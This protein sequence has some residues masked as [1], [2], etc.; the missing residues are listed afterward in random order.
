MSNILKPLVIKVLPL[1]DG[2]KMPN[3]NIPN[4]ILGALIFDFV[5][6]CKVSGFWHHAATKF[7]K[8]WPSHYITL[9]VL[10]LVLCSTSMRVCCSI[11]CKFNGASL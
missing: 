6:R 11:T 1:N 2:A 8:S 4:V 5:A 9:N 7:F 10:S 3:F